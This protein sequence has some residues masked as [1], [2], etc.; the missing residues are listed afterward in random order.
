[1][2]VAWNC[3]GNSKRLLC[4]SSFTFSDYP[5]ILFRFKTIIILKK[6]FDKLLV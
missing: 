1:M 5:V 2:V 4:E 6:R 3:A